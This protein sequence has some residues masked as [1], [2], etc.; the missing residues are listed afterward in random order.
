MSVPLMPGKAQIHQDEVRAERERL[1]EIPP[2]RRPP[3]PRENPPAQSS[4]D[5]VA[6]A[7]VVIDYEDC[8]Q[9]RYL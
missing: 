4:A 5:G 1:V 6:Q 8:L 7:F 2:G 3:G 9:L